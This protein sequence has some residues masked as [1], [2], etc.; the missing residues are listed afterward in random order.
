MTPDTD[1]EADQG[2]ILAMPRP[3]L[4]GLLTLF[5]GVSIAITWVVFAPLG[6][7]PVRIVAAGA[8]MGAMSHYMLFINRLFVS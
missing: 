2:S 3:L 7:G 6:W 4:W 8:M 5:V 1:T